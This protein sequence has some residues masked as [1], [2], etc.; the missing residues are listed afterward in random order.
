MAEVK[1]QTIDTG[2]GFV[3]PYELV[4]RAYMIWRNSDYTR[5]P[6]PEE[7]D[8]VPEAW[9]QDMMTLH[10]IVEH[11]RPATQNPSQAGNRSS[12]LSN[13]FNRSPNP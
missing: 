11:K 8:S 13:W 2:W 1:G 12:W 7:V 6:T 9:L 5:L 4:K 10:Q 3:Y